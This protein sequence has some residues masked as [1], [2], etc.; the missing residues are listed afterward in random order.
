MV[1]DVKALIIIIIT[2]FI[3]VTSNQDS[4]MRKMCVFQMWVGIF[5][6]IINFNLN[7]LFKWEWRTGITSVCR[8]ASPSRAVAGLVHHCLPLWSSFCRSVSSLVSVCVWQS[9]SGLS[10]LVFV[11][12]LDLTRSSKVTRPKLCCGQDNKTS[13]AICCIYYFFIVFL[14]VFN[15]LALFFLNSVLLK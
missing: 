12:L 6:V 13:S 14:F 15:S 5:F 8:I 11:Q 2:C 1:Y 4:K 10:G 9:Y 7:A 3:Y